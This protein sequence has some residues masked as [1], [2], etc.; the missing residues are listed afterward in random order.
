MKVLL[1]IFEALLIIIFFILSARGNI[2]EQNDIGYSI[3]TGII[4]LWIIGYLT[5]LDKGE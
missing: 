2:S 3:I 1:T 5:D 4:Y